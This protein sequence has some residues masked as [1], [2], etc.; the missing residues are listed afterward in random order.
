MIKA[1][2]EKGLEAITDLFN[3]IIQGNTIPSDWDKSIIKNCFKG[4]G[5]AMVCGNYRGLKLLEHA[6]KLFE[7]V[8]EKI[9]RDSVDIDSMQFGF[10]PG[11]GTIDAIF[12]YHPTD[13]GKVHCQ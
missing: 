9:I 5:D 3:N 1:S 11:R 7:R 8:M 6:M 4:K 12:M 13:T 10:M 2:G